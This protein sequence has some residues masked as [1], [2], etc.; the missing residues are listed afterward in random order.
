MSARVFG[1]CAVLCSFALRLRPKIGRWPGRPLQ[2]W[3]G[4]FHTA[5]SWSSPCHLQDT[6]LPSACSIGA[7]P[8]RNQAGSRCNGKIWTRC[9]TLQPKRR[10][11]VLCKSP[12]LQLLSCWSLLLL[13][14]VTER[15]HYAHWIPNSYSAVELLNSRGRARVVRRMRLKVEP[16]NRT[17]RRDQEQRGGG[18][19]TRS[20]RRCA[21]LQCRIQYWCMC[22]VVANQSVALAAGH[23]DQRQRAQACQ[24][25]GRSEGRGEPSARHVACK[26]MYRTF[27]FL[28][29]FH[30]HVTHRFFYVVTL[31][32]SDRIT[33]SQRVR[34]D[35]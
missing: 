4:S 34:D 32:D 15:V 21:Y 25:P 1:C 24:R 28:V 14:K 18:T 33:E 5:S 2:I 10:P 11:R 22:S 3:S 19:Y 31:T 26:T 13:L 20:G 12:W 16:N 29:R 6:S 7:F 8:V 9:S 17:W 23:S 27:E 30:T 35:R